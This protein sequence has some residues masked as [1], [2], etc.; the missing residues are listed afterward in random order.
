MNT[1]A[2]N[3]E[4]KEVEM[5]YSHYKKSY[6]N[7]ETVKG[8]YDKIHK[9]IKVLVPENIYNRIMKKAGNSLK[10]YTAKFKDNTEKTFEISFNYFTDKGLEKQIKDYCKNNNCT[11]V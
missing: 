10:Y 1:I 6:D 11:E 4:Y 7:Y 3:I 5:A 9:T 8:S 2:V